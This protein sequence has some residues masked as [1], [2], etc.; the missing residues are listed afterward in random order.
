MSEDTTVNFSP[1]PGQDTREWVEITHAGSGGPPGNT[2]ATH[3]CT[4]EAFDTVWKAKG[5]EIE[6]AN[7]SAPV[8]SDTSAETVDPYGP[9]A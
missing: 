3:K 4:R 2:T 9:P 8:P 6:N 1:P 5:W 7:P